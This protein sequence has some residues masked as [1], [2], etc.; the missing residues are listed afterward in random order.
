MATGA[1]ARVTVSCPLRSYVKVNTIAGYTDLECVCAAAIHAFPYTRE[2]SQMRA[3]P[4][5]LHAFARDADS[6]GTRW[7][8]TGRKPA[9]TGGPAGIAQKAPTALCH[10]LTASAF[11]AVVGTAAGRT[12]GW[13]LST[14]AR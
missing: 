12:R 6:D 5:A 11:V 14:T 2:H 9:R 10:S 8:Q 4:H 3:R 13:S 1:R 7:N